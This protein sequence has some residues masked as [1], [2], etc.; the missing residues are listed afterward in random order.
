MWKH[1]LA[2]AWASRSGHQHGK[3]GKKERKLWY[4]SGGIFLPK[5]LPND[6]YQNPCRPKREVCPGWLNN[7]SLQSTTAMMLCKKESTSPRYPIPIVDTRECYGLVTP[8]S[9]TEK[10]AP[11]NKRPTRSGPR[12]GRA[13]RRPWRRAR[14]RRPSWCGHG[15]SWPACRP[16]R[17][18]RCWRPS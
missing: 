4:L 17:R 7:A 13:S 9:E 18:R 6:E 11:K 8:E 16:L 12:L 2:V 14:R 3:Y 15:A 10:S 1:C 5:A